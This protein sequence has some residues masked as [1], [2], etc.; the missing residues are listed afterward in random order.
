MYT[1]LEQAVPWTRKPIQFSAIL[2]AIYGAIHGEMLK[3]TVQHISSIVKLMTSTLYVIRKN[4]YKDM[5][6][7]LENKRE[8]L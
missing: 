6:D 8:L 2:L 5:I 4:I 7:V 3:I 1:N